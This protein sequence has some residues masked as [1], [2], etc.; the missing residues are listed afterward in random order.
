MTRQLR[1]RKARPS[2]AELAGFEDEPPDAGENHAGPSTL[3]EA[4]E[5]ELEPAPG[6]ED[7]DGDEDQDAQ[8]DVEEADELDDEVYGKPTKVIRR[9]AAAS[10]STSTKSRTK[11]PAVKGK[12]TGKAKAESAEGTTTIVGQIRRP[13]GKMYALPTPSVHHRHRAVPL[14]SRG[15][16]TERLTVRPSLFEPPSLTLTS[17][18]TE[19][20]KV[21]ERV[22]KAWGFNVGHG[23]LWE[24][25][26]D[27]GW[28]KEAI[29]TGN[30]TDIEAKRRPRVHLDVPVQDGWEIMS[31]EYVSF[32][33]AKSRSLG[34]KTESHCRAA[35]PF[36][37]TDDIT[38][39]EG[40]LKPP[41][42]VSCFFGP[43]KS[44]IRQDV[45]MFEAFSMCLCA[46]YMIVC[47]MLTDWMLAKYTSESQAHVFNAGAPV[48]GMDWCPIHTTDRPGGILLPAFR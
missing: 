33:Y 10:A 12:G 32:S 15:G 22:N 41:P 37:P 20:P 21:S 36:L 43:F 3:F 11:R 26:E 44:Q 30:N 31:L 13:K 34:Y 17:S 2:Y 38:T 19:R 25:A 14:Y 39:E 4:D 42:P 7:E 23:P 47:F 40:D 24:L 48:W 45:K 46:A 29:N 28:Y 9:T 18:F 8:Y 35:S 16:R 1:L 27:R 5:K 6:D